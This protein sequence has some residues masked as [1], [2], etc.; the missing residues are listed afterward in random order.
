MG[1]DLK[2][3][4]GKD[5]PLSNPTR[6][7]IMLTLVR[8]G[9]QSMSDLRETLSLTFGNLDSHIKRLKKAAFVKSEKAFTRKGIRTV[10]VA[11]RKGCL[12]AI[13][14]ANALK[15]LLDVPSEPPAPV[16]EVFVLKKGG[17]LL[18]HESLQDSSI[19]DSALVGATLTALQDFVKVS[20]DGE[21]IE[22]I[23]FGTRRL[24]IRR[25]DN[26]G[27]ALVLGS[28]SIDVWEKKI[29]DLVEKLEERYGKAVKEWSGERKEISGLFNE[30]KSFLTL[31]G[32]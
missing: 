25:D 19:V 27:I 18:A 14:Q 29:G 21:D 12:T 5:S 6:L 30:L 11:T 3:I 9:A 28:G 10:L 13:D 8:E 7:A 22:S 4:I 23:Q 17:T 26:I 32:D 24:L 16:L 1:K 20:W 15:A 2:D 31:N